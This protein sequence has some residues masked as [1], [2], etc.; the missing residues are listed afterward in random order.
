MRV[1]LRIS[2]E[3]N[4]GFAAQKASHNGVETQTSIKHRYWIATEKSQISIDK[5]KSLFLTNITI[6]LTT[7]LIW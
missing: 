1:N 4:A 6:T 5:H 7:C 2:E 3:S